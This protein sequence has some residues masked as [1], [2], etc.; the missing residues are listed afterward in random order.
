MLTVTVLQTRPKKK[1]L[2]RKEPLSHEGT[3]LNTRPPPPLPQQAKAESYTNSNIKS[4]DQYRRK[5]KASYNSEV[6]FSCHVWNDAKQKNVW[7]I[8][9][10]LWG[11]SSWPC[12]S[13]IRQP[14]RR[15]RVL[16]EAAAR[17]TN[18]GR[19]SHQDGGNKNRPE[20]GRSLLS[21]VSWG[22]SNP[23]LLGERQ[24]F[25]PKLVDKGWTDTKKPG[26]HRR[27][28]DDIAM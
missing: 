19:E 25:Y 18:R 1:R 13:A 16:P 20:R 15:D 27:G 14:K 6:L 28:L 12:V 4:R 10:W 8:N 2:F 22:E 17:R 5:A 23:G 21:W 11:P 3:M 26:L 7:Q 24:V 9:T